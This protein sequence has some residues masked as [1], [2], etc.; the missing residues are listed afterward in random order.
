MSKT[1]MRTE[2]GREVANRTYFVTLANTR[3][4]LLRVPMMAFITAFVLGVALIPLVSMIFF[5][6]YEGFFPLFWAHIVVI[7]F[8]FLVW[9]LSAFRGWIF[10]FQVLATSL[11]GFFA[12][13]LVYASCFL[14]ISIGSSVDDPL[15]GQMVALDRLALLGVLGFFW[16]CGAFVVHVVLLR[17]RLR[18]G[19]SAQRT[20]G[21]LIAVSRVSR[22]KTAWITFGV[23]MVGGNIATRNQYV[24][25]T[26]G[27]LGLLF[28]ASVMP[29]LP[30]EF[31]YLAF[32]KSKDHRYWE[33]RPPQKVEKQERRS[34]LRTI[35]KWFLV[36]IAFNLLMLILTLMARW[37]VWG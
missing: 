19:H 10:R 16:L 27:V 1:N 28:L 26:I 22:Y 15:G 21:N 5:H 37:G 7:G 3:F 23:I 36:F 2:E 29:S 11:M 32:L 12:F 30:V 13:M 14:F 35:L 17:K 8:S 9:V 25:M 33:K 4:S 34:R 20:V 24:P 6:R 31:A 18:V